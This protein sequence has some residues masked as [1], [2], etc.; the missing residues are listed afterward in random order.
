MYSQQIHRYLSAVSRTQSQ[1]CGSVEARH[2]SCRVCCGPSSIFV[3]SSSSRIPMLTNSCMLSSRKHAHTNPQTVPAGLPSPSSPSAPV[4]RAV[5]GWMDGSVHTSP[6]L[7]THPCC[8]IRAVQRL[9]NQIIIA[10][11]HT[12]GEARGQWS[13]MAKRWTDAGRGNIGT[14]VLSGCWSSQSALESSDLSGQF[15]AHPLLV[16]G[17]FLC[18]NQCYTFNCCPS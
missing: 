9:T 18:H 14:P 8:Y 2:H 7:P 16:C 1:S 3:S 10:T 11:G 12:L 5:C 4:D 17:V 6:L 15:R 13:N